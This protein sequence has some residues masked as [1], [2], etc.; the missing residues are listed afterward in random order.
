M[1]AV[2]PKRTL[3]KNQKCLQFRGQFTYLQL[4]KLCLDS[5]QRS[6]YRANL[7]STQNSVIRK[8]ATLVYMPGRGIADLI[9]LLLE[10]GGWTWDEHHPASR[11]EFLALKAET[12]HGT[13]PYIR[14]DEGKAVRTFEQSMAI[15]QYLARR[16]GLYPRH[17]DEQYKADMLGSLLCEFTF[18]IASARFAPDPVAALK[19]LRTETAPRF[20]PSLDRALCDNLGGDGFCGATLSCVDLQ[21]FV[22]L[23][24]LRDFHPDAF[25][26]YPQLEGFVEQIAALPCAVNFLQ[27]RFGLPDAAYVAHCKSIVVGS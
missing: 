14:I 27:R 18:L 2:D 11:V 22:A 4:G 7:M 23:T 25:D 17:L 20:L 10:A 8:Q 9:R 13:L 3:K 24:F 16:A 12:V 15:S 26:D 19:K 21:A 6:C 5:R 1:A